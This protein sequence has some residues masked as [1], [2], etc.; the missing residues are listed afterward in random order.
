M[1]VIFLQTGIKEAISVA[2]F[3]R[4]FFT[5]L[6]RLNATNQSITDLISIKC[7]TLFP[8]KFFRVTGLIVY[9]SCFQPFL[10]HGTVGL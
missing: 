4:L 6:G 3:I 5:L 7:Q 9:D 1:K 10:I 8:Y 2:L